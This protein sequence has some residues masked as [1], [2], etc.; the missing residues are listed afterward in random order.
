MSESSRELLLVE[1]N[2]VFA[3]HATRSLEATGRW[4]VTCASTLD[5]A[6]AL[7]DEQPF[8]AILADLGLP[9]S[10]GRE[11]FEAVGRL[12]DD[13][14]VIVLTNH[15]Q[16]Q[17]GRE[18][19]RAGAADFITK[20]DFDGES[21]TWVLDAAVERAE[22]RREIQEHRLVRAVESERRRIGRDL[23]D[24][25]IQRLF[26]AGLELERCASTSELSEEG[27][28]AVRSALGAID[29]AVGDLRTAIDQLHPSSAPRSLGGEF[30]S[31]A[32]EIEA[33]SGRAIQ[34]R[35]FGDT[36][37]ID[38][39]IGQVMLS[40]FREGVANAVR[41]GAGPIEIELYATDRYRI[42]IATG[43]A[44]GTPRP[45]GGRGLASV[46]DRAH[47]LHGRCRLDID[48]DGSTFDWEVPCTQPLPA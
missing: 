26:A 23:H 25:V 37:R 28:E 44:T 7:I 42:R 22:F 12:V 5:D 11:T 30:E 40:V 3:A 8:E 48:D 34:L 39:D 4:R 27:H 47:Q 1:D 41:H 6:T 29:A 2:P 20:T 15:D 17:L 14:P 16:A 36:E 9:D 43:L 46:T 33:A 32:R 35:V 10:D 45:G 21:I 38:P 31:V 13:V 18:L 24:R 19:L